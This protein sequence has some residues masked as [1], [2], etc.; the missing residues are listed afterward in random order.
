MGKFV[1]LDGTTLANVTEDYFEFNLNGKSIL[2]LEKSGDIFVKGKL[3][4]NDVSVVYALREF[5]KHVERGNVS[6]HTSD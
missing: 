2:R 6:E 4:E 3:V 1:T 5:L